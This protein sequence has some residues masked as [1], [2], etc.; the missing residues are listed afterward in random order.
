[1]SKQ[2]AFFLSEWEIFQQEHPE[3][4]TRKKGSSN[5]R[6]ITKVYNCETCGLDKIC[7]HPRIKRYG[8]GEKDILVVGL[9]PGR[10]ED[11]CGIPL[12]GP[13]GSLTKRM[14]NLVGIDLDRD[15]KRINIVQCY[16]GRSKKGRDKEPTA[17]QIKCCRQ[18]LLKDIEETKPKLIICLGAPAINAVLNS[19]S[20]ETFKAGQMQGK[21]IPCHE[22]NCWVGCLYHPAFFLHRRNNYQNP[23]DEN[24]MA[25]GLANIIDVIDQPLPQPLTEEGNECITDVDEAIAALEYFSDSEKPVAY[26]YEG[27]IL[28]PYD[29]EA[30]ILSVAL[31]NEVSSATFIPIGLRYEKTKEYVFNSEERT[32]ILIALANFIKSDAPKIV[33]N[34]NLEEM[35]NRIILS[36]RMNHFIHDTMIAAHVLNSNQK[37][38]LD[39]MVYEMTGHEYKDMVDAT[40]MIDESMEKVFHYNCWDSRYTLML[41]YKQIILLPQEGRLE[42]FN[43]FL[44]KGFQGL[45]NLREVGVNIN[46][47]V[48]DEL[49]DTYSIE[50]KQRIDEVRNFSEV[51]K[52]MERKKAGMRQKE[53]EKGVEFNLDSPIQLAKVLYDGYNVKLY[54]ETKTKKG[55]TDVETL[56][57][58]ENRTKNPEVKSLISSIFRFRKTCSMLERIAQY[59]RVMDLNHRVHPSYHLFPATYRSGASDPNIQNV[60]IRDDELR[61]FRRC[62][63]PS[64]GNIFLEVDYS[65]IE[66][67]VF[68]MASGDVNLIYQIIESEKWDI[69]HPEGGPNPFDPHR[70]WA[71]ELYQKDYGIINKDIERYASK[72][73]FVFPSFYGSVPS[74]MARYEAFVE[75][76]ITESHLK[77]VQDLFWEEYKDVRAWQKNIIDTYLSCGYVEA[78]SGF[79]R[80]GPLTIN[81]LYN[82]PIQGPA[83]HLSLDCLSTGR[84]KIWEK[85]IERHLKTRPCFEVHDS[86]MFDTVPE[87]KEEV[88]NLVEEI[89]LSKRFPWQGNVPLAVE[90][91]WSDT[92]WY[93]MKKLVR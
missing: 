69:A 93:E 25:F 35:W 79:R 80:Y 67:R 85:L 38:S 54:K 20:L 88:V 5:K 11:G 62:I 41:Y 34:L 78:I 46:V 16:P 87:E 45:I 51:K 31:S 26:D 50:Q 24:L 57:V 4:F 19:R 13:S 63:I 36:T 9:C 3:R 68:A 73:G 40:N 14:F 92:N 74:S 77:K 7:N 17:D 28:D 83:F 91:E 43:S 33:Q 65:G 66:V 89:M 90:W 72:N 56:Q 75:A 60:F 8:K 86:I 6:S 21:V 52:F 70:R 76:G 59:R 22:H 1:M 23:N 44:T 82:T 10:V 53:I 37:K 49:E 81:Q 58:I 48:L 27:P 32:R 47:D 71:A 39:Y 61:Q 18:N 30:E 84:D 12:K 42:E 2:K 64:P 15:C 55:S 29:P